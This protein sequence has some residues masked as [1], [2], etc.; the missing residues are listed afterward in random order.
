MAP[1]GN[2][3]SR[4]SFGRSAVDTI[5]IGDVAERTGLAPSAIRYYESEGLL[6][7]PSRKGG[8][9]AFSPEV[10]SRIMVIRIARDLGFSLDDIHTLL[11]GFSPATP[12]P[13]RW[14]EL[15]RRKLPEVD[16]VLRRARAMKQLFE[17]GLGCECVDVTDCFVYDCNPPVQIGLTRRRA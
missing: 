13:E 16:E 12:P 7:H 14:Q 8:K 9:R 2:L 15:A 5:S 11:D 17:K 4:G 1:K 3:R 6:P 10:V